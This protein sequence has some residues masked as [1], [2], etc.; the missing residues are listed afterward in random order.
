MKEQRKNT[1]F[2]W[3]IIF[4]LW[5]RVFALQ[6]IHITDTHIGT[7]N[8]AKNLITFCQLVR[9]LTPKPDFIIHTGDITEFGTESEFQT[10]FNIVSSLDIPIYHILG[11]HDVRWNGAGWI[12]AKKLLNNYSRNYSFTKEGITFIALDSSF[13]YSQYGIIDPSQLAWLKE[14]LANLPQNQPIFLFTHHPI[15]TSG[16]FLFGRNA[17]LEAL[18]PY[19]VVLFLTGHGHSNRLWQFDGIT[20]LM[21]K[22]LMDADANFRCL[23]IENGEIEISLWTLD[24]KEREDQKVKIQLKRA[25]SSSHA[26]TSQNLNYSPIL[27]INGAIQADLLAFENI[28]ITTSWNGEVIAIDSREKKEIWRKMFDSP[29]VTSSAIY[30]DKIFIPFLNGT[31]RALEIKS[32][33]NVWE[34][35]LPQPITG[36]LL[37]GSGKIFVPANTSLFALSPNEGKILWQ[38]DLNGA[39]ESCPL[40][41][42]NTLYIATWNKSLFALNAGNGSILWQKET[43]RSRYYSP[44][45]CIP[46]LWMDKLII[47]QAYDNTT[48]KGG[49]L[50]LDKTGNIIWQVEGNFGYSTPSVQGDKLFIAS[51]EGK[52]F[53]ISSGGKIIWNL[54]LGS[55]CF[56]SRPVIR[57]DKLYIVSFNNVLFVVDIR[58]GRLVKKLPLGGDG[59]CL[60]TPVIVNDNIFIGDMMGNLYSISLS[61]L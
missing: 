27:K 7:G 1:V 43:A 40:L 28:V 30:Q 15:M 58:D 56:N 34:T 53:C 57:G 3:V 17:L 24:G 37:V 39:L 46:T 45:T 19:N 61:S 36:R 11:N 4:L 18:K 35:K 2:V 22:G 26:I 13:P 52:L 38:R 21:T 54:N 5:G 23:K 41:V 14:T 6:F 12:I 31:L 60:S 42:D 51:M 33:K 59:C 32:G 8:G 44:A 48:K 47:S 29:I 55:A 10:Y 25:A 50:A 20:F 49:V 16:N 9:N